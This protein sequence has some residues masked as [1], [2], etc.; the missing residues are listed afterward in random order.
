MGAPQSKEQKTSG[1]SKSKQKEKDKV[2]F[3]SPV[4]I[5]TEHSGKLAY[6]LV[7]VIV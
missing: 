7:L 1:Q 3:S 5:F 4:N 6:L 2:K